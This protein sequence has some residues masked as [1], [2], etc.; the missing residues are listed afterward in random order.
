MANVK[1]R[2]ENK[3]TGPS[4]MYVTFNTTAAEII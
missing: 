1:P 3:N 2:K 4:T